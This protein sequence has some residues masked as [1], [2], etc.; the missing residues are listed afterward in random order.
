MS[1]NYPPT[2]A[3]LK[4]ILPENT[5]SWIVP[6]IKEDPLV[7]E[8]LCSVR[9]FLEVENLSQVIHQP[10]DC[11]PA[12]LALKGLNY[13]TNPE[14]LRALPIQAVDPEFHSKVKDSIEKDPSNLDQ[15]GLQ[16]LFFRERLRETGSWENLAI[17]LIN[18]CPTSLA[19]LYGIVPDQIDLLRAILSSSGSVPVNPNLNNRSYHQV[20]HMVLSNPVPPEAQVEIFNLLF[21]DL[22]KPQ[23]ILLLDLLSSLRPGLASQLSSHIT[24][25]HS[26]SDQIAIT[27]NDQVRELTNLY[28]TAKMER[29]ADK[30]P[31][32]IIHLSKSIDVARQIQA[33]LGF[34]L[35]ITSIRQKDIESA[36]IAWKQAVDQNNQKP[37]YLAGYLLT[38]IDAG[39]LEA[40]N[41]LISGL[42][43][44][45]LLSDPLILIGKTRLAAHQWALNS[46]PQLGIFEE[47]STSGRQSLAYLE[48]IK[49]SDET[50]NELENPIFRA[51]LGLH[52]AS[53]FNELGL[54]DEARRAGQVATQALPNDQKLNLFQAQ[55]LH[56][57][58]MHAEATQ[59][60]HLAVALSPNDMI[61]RRYLASSMEAAEE[62]QAAC[63][64]RK[65]I[66]DRLE[67]PDS[68]DWH[69]LAANTLRTRQPDRTIQACM[70]ALKTD[71][72]NGITYALLGEATREIGEANEAQNYLSQAIDLTPE[73]AY[74]WLALSRLYQFTGQTQKSLETLRAAAQIVSDRPEIHLALGETY[75]DQE[76]P[77]QALS[78]FRFAA[79]LVQN[80]PQAYSINPLDYLSGST[81]STKYP[82]FEENYLKQS[83]DF[84]APEQTG[85][86]ITTRI[87]LRLGQV[88]HRLGHLEEARQVL[89]AEYRKSPENID[90]AY[91]YAQSL[92]ALGDLQAALF[93]LQLVIDS[94]PENPDPYLDF[95][96]CLVTLK[97]QNIHRSVGNHLQLQEPETENVQ[98]LNLLPEQVIPVLEK[99]LQLKPENNEAKAL[100]AEAW[101]AKGELSAAMD[102]FSDLLETDLTH[103][104]DWQSRLSLDMGEVAFKSGKI[105]TAI[106]AFLD[107]DQSNP[108]VQQKLAEAYF[109]IGL[110]E[111]AF[112]AAKSTLQL[113]PT[114]LELLI[115]FANF[116][117]ELQGHPE[118]ILPEA[119]KEV[120]SALK[121]AVK[122]AP[123]RGDLLVFLGKIQK[124]IGDIQEAKNTYLKL[125]PEESQEPALE[126]TSRDLHLAGQSLIDLGDSGSAI[127]CLEKA[128]RLNPYPVRKIVSP[129]SQPEPSIRNLLITL[130][131]AYKQT[132]D[133]TASLDT[134]DQAIKISPL[135]TELHL[136]KADQ[137]L[138]YSRV[139]SNGLDAG[140]KVFESSARW[141]ENALEQMPLDANLLYYSVLL[142][143]AMGNLPKA[144]FRAE[145]LV[146]TLENPSTT[147]QNNIYISH[148]LLGHVTPQA[149]HLLAGEI[150]AALLQYTNVYG[151]LE[152]FP[153][154]FAEVQGFNLANDQNRVVQPSDLD[155]YCLR[156]ERTL[157]MGKNDLAMKDLSMV[158][159]FA[160]QFPRILAIQARLVNRRGDFQGAKD[161]LKSAMDLNSQGPEIIASQ[162]RPVTDIAEV[163]S[164]IAARRSIAHAALELYEWEIALPIY[165][166]ISKNAA[167]EPGAHLDLARAIVL[168]A[169]YALLCR[170]VEVVRNAPGEDTLSNETWRAFEKA[171]LVTTRQLASNQKSIHP[172]SKALIAKW[173]TRGLS[174]FKPGRK[175]AQAFAALQQDPDDVAALIANLRE[176][177]AIE[178]AALQAR[179]HPQHPD[180][181]IQL[182]L[183]LAN[184]KPRQALVAAQTAA[185]ILNKVDDPGLKDNQDK[186]FWNRTKKIPL[187]YA[188]QALL[189]HSTGNSASDSKIAIE[190]IRKALECWPDEPRWHALASEILLCQD[191]FANMPNTET[192]ISHLEQA[193]ALEQAN[194]KLW[195]T[196]GN[197]F[198]QSGQYLN[199][200]SRLEQA[201]RLSPENSQ[202]WLTLAKAYS[203]NNDLQQAL[204]C[205][206]QAVKLAPG[207]SAP[208]LLRAEIAIKHKDYENA[209]KDSQAALESDPENHSGLLLLS[210]SLTGLNRPE[211]ALRTLD[212]VLSHKNPDLSLLVERARLVRKTKGLEAAVQVLQT[213][214]SQFPDRF[215]PQILLAEALDEIGDK[216]EAKRIAQTALQTSRNTSMEIDQA[217]LAGLHQLLGRIAQQSGQLDQAI[218]H[219]SE[220]TRLNPHVIEPYLGLGSV[221]LERRQHAQALSVYQKAIAAA[222]QESQAYYQAGLVLKES[223]DYIEAE[224]M[225]RQA[226]KLAPDD[227]SIQRH[228]GA[229]VALNLVHNRIAYG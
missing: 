145:Q 4:L 142:N 122:L 51:Y 107:A 15:A 88:L 150:S 186:L 84:L 108:F 126:I 14:A 169:E 32:E 133:F 89:E 49:S 77:T 55:I 65:Q 123:H 159:E 33:Q 3:E 28:E 105:E 141:V 73:N 90:I 13:P 124:K 194:P 74:P 115:W 41:S 20:L 86:Q 95:A 113:A 135:D 208:L 38:L 180:V 2:I 212:R 187:I 104:P 149:A 222:P 151:Y 207:E 21:M 1:S 214:V 109:A 100:L 59:G 66:I 26:T 6:A 216:E 37:H 197:L 102:A 170:E 228:L 223:K 166:E 179:L 224:R 56:R 103:N 117:F 211:Q 120:I 45:N 147:A 58:G 143:R 184:E 164:G 111:D 158:L 167:A 165:E 43:N 191:E 190:A 57:C 50:S 96:R 144:L 127:L 198:L 172:E 25:E 99:V 213:L 201:S 40:A 176:I 23:Q 34:Q 81:S 193:I 188:I 128:L 16:A 153:T 30:S 229:I 174:V 137:L 125:I 195:V 93:P 27:I 22:G 121:H 18:A 116:V 94:Q 205:V 140:A 24:N 52:L 110:I 189:I 46:S 203:Q 156:A 101:A 7:W 75:L 218:H 63:T 62:W 225:L 209:R 98:D 87:S 83:Q 177:G 162:Q 36:L 163:Y 61:L 76:S 132:G 175:T 10:Q 155:F 97:D 70:Q 148:N 215:T 182:A 48:E 227:L 192:A 5:W 85:K 29:I 138:E 139:K 210:T 44:K 106:A 11:T 129:F 161:L 47:I 64:E 173:Q 78:S 136:S 35:A 19:C 219:L 196:L 154:S 204:S 12:S 152:K 71:D 181:L 200:I 17:D 217:E 185:D 92:V 146:D 226:A 199:A 171:I 160:P 80:L 183:T 91:S 79:E 42:E 131:H 54:L 220:A 82:L 53:A 202:I 69:Y 68:S 72:Q 157:D 31:G 221:H 9:E 39:Q 114:S 178:E 119:P 67:N 206:N 134:L 60:V 130:S 112:N 168:R 8:F 118:A